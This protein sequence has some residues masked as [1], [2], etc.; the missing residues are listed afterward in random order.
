[1]STKIFFPGG[2]FG[3]SVNT[4]GGLA[5]IMERKLEKISLKHYIKTLGYIWCFIFDECPVS[6]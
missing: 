4:P 1:M 2:F 3:F 5:E 6:R